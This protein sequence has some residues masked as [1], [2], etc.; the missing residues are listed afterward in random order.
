MRQKLV[1]FLCSLILVSLA[2]ADTKPTRGRYPDGKAYRTDTAGY[3][4]TD[5][6]AEL[7]V[8]I[9]D[10][11]KQLNELE[12]TVSAKDR[13]LNQYKLGKAKATTEVTPTTRAATDY[14]RGDCAPETSALKSEIT[15]LQSALRTKEMRL[16]EVTHLANQPQVQCPKFECPTL[17]CDYA[18][19][20]RPLEQQIALLSASNANTSAKEQEYYG[21]IKDLN[22]KLTTTQTELDRRSQAL[23]SMQSELDHQGQ[24]LS[25]Y[26][27]LEKELR[28]ELATQAESLTLAQSQAASVEQKYA[29]NSIAEAPLYQRTAQIQAR[30]SLDLARSARTESQQVDATNMTTLKAAIT[31]SSNSIQQLIT[32][33]KSIFD[34]ITA[35]K[36]GITIQLRTLVAKNGYSLDSLRALNRTATNPGTASTIAQ[37][38]S[39]IEGILRDDI[40][41]LN[42]LGKL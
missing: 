35:S 13:E 25:Q 18:A 32:E 16:A 5:H 39:E 42:R 26:A 30:A 27:A 15:T 29:Q 1:V 36:K 17:E 20:K 28:A 31:Q 2:Y 23:A 14:A 34:R 21:Q 41:T 22:D 4:L 10:L 11:N 7:E 37:G 3:Q 40:A 19:V 12:D 9:D 38:M 24:K 6:I 8:T 33:R